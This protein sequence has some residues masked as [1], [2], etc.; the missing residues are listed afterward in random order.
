[1]QPQTQTTP[2]TPDEI[3]QGLVAAG[4]SQAEIARRCGVSRVMVNAVVHGRAV[5]QRV[6]AEIASALGKD[7][8]Q[9][10]EIRPKPEPSRPCPDCPLSSV[11]Q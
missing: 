11:N 4:M 9:V 10:F 7:P 3:K 8:E 6:M 2:M 5:S 1:M